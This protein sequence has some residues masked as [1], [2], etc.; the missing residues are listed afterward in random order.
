VEKIVLLIG[1]SLIV[2]LVFAVYLYLVS[3]VYPMFTLRLEWR[4][5]TKER[6]SL[7]RLWSNRN[8]SPPPGDRGERKL[9]FP[10]GRAMIYLPAPKYRRYIQ[11]YALVKRDGCTYIRCRIHEKIAHIRYDVVTFD[12][13]GRFLD[14]LHVSERITE[15]GCTA[16][17]RLPRNTAYACVTLRKADGMYEGND[18]STGYS[19]KWIM[20]YTVL[21]VV[22]ALLAA[23]ILYRSVS[24]IL[25]EF[26]Y[27]EGSPATTLVIAGVLGAVH[28]AWIVLRYHLQNS[29]G[30]KK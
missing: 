21:S 19:V 6:F 3:S 2:P 1:N 9:V 29:K 16:A 5:P 7:R 26:F 15:T 28:A 4:A 17:V 22:T 18:V 24:E 11:R 25:Y 13:K 27:L 30:M 14:V 10:G 8:A 12:V 20:I 23:T